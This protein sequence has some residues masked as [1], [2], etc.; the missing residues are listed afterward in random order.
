MKTTTEKNVVVPTT[1]ACFT[2]TAI[3]EGAFENISNEAMT[4]L[5]LP[6]TLKTIG[7]YA[8]GGC[9]GIPISLSGAVITSL[10]ENAFEDCDGLGSIVLGEG[11]VEIPASAFLRCTGL[12]SLVLP[13]TLTKIDESAFE[14]CQELS[15]I[16]I[17]KG[18]T[19]IGHSA[20]RDCDHLITLLFGG[21]A[22]ELTAL[23]EGTEPTMNEALL[24]LEET[25]C[26]YSEAQPTTEGSYWHYD[27]NRMPKVW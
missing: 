16:L 25:A 7:A 18:V 20:F 5:T 2:V 1:I 8:F 14:G 21:N 10:G 27:E 19:E 13:T 23:F 9:A 11:L 17:H 24:N 12:T 22:E 6:S 3:G 26:L 4:S 15:S